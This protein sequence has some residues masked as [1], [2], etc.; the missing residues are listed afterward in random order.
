MTNKIKIT[1]RQLVITSMFTAVTIVLSQL[2]LPLPSGV[3]IT[4]QTFAI[5]LC[6]YVLGWQLGLLSIL[7]YILLGTAGVPVFA[8]FKGGIGVVVGMT[9]GFIWGFLFMV[10]LI[11]LYTK[12]KS[13]IIGIGLGIIGLLLCHLFGVIQFAFVTS[14][15]FVH[16]FLLV[17]APYL[18]KDIISIIVA[19]FA[20]IAIRK[21]LRSAHLVINVEN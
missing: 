18:I 15:S 20:A 7:A 3:P 12:F 9:G 4:L 16:S 8:N 6:G 5:A 11:G 17:S 13:K 19:Y 14:T 21:S 10:F 2:S 1:T